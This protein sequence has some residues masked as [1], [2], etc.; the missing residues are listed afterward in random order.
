MQNALLLRLFSPDIYSD[1][2]V[3]SLFIVVV[4]CNVDSLISLTY[5]CKITNECNVTLKYF[6][7]FIHMNCNLITF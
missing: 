2:S 6:S 7:Y 4:W 1:E 5:I 3:A